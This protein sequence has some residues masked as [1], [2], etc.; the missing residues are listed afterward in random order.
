MMRFIGLQF[1]GI[2]P[3]VREYSID[4]SALSASGMFLIQGET[5]SGKSTILDAIT[6]ALYDS[7]S[8]DTS[9]AGRMRSKFLQM[10]RQET[11]TDLIFEIRNHV[12]RVRREPQYRI[13]KVR[14]EG[15]T[16]HRASATLWQIDDNIRALYDAPDERGS[17]DRFFEYAEQHSTVLG[18]KANDVA[19]ELA[20]IIGLTRKQFTTTV[21]LAQGQ[22]AKLLSMQPEERTQLLADLVDAHI[23]EQ[24]QRELQEERKQAHAQVEQQQNMLLQHIL[25]MRTIAQEYADFAGTHARDIREQLA[26]DDSNWCV[27]EQ[28]TLNVPALSIEDIEHQ[29]Q[30]NTQLMIQDIAAWQEDIAQHIDETQQRW[31]Q[32]R[33]CTEYANTVT[34]LV[35]RLQQYQEEIVKQIEQQAAI[36][37]YQ[38][39]LERAHDAAPIIVTLREFDTQQ[40]ERAAAQQHITQL[41]AQLEQLPQ[42]DALQAQLEQARAAQTAMLDLQHQLEQCRRQ[43]QLWQTYRVAQAEYEQANE[44]LDAQNQ[45]VQAAKQHVVDYGSSKSLQTQIEQLQQQAQSYATAEQER[46]SAQQALTHAKRA[47]QLSIKEEEL[48][49]RLEH[50]EQQLNDANTS[51]QLAQQ[52]ITRDENARLAA[53]LQDG[54]PCPVCGSLEHPDPV[55]RPDHVPDAEFVARLTKQQQ[56][57]QTH[58]EQLN[59]QYAAMHAELGTEEQ[60]A[61]GGVEQCEQALELAQERLAQYEQYAEQITA[62]QTKLEHAQELE[63]HYQSSEHEAERLQALCTTKQALAQQAYKQLDS[64]QREEDIHARIEE[65]N[66]QL[67]QQQAQADQLDALKQQMKLLERIAQDIATQRALL[68]KHTQSI[69]RLNA[70]IEQACKQAN[71]ADSKAVRQAMLSDGERE[72]IETA[73][74]TYEHA[75]AATDEQGKQ[76]IAQLKTM[77][78]TR[79]TQLMDANEA[80]LALPG[81]DIDALYTII[82]EQTS[83]RERMADYNAVFASVEAQ[84]RTLDVT[85]LQSEEAQAMVQRDQARQLATTVEHTHTQIERAIPHLQEALQQWASA[86]RNY[87]PIRAM[88]ALANATPDSPAAEKM[89]LI[90]YSVTERC[91]DM[92]EHANEIL[93]DIQGGIYELRLDHSNVSRNRKLGLPISV[94]DRRSDTVRA[95]ASLSG[96]ETFFVS[97][98]LALALADEMSAGQGGLSLQT[99]FIDEGFGSLSDDYLDDVIEVLHAIARHRAI[100]II[101]HVERLKDQVPAGIHVSR[102][103]ADGESTLQVHA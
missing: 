58:V 57:Y 102:M 23:F 69:E 17:A 59:I 35:E 85:R 86:Y 80:F 68:D 42:Q 28:H 9:D 12:Y 72:E 10:S 4:F 103:R 87:E 24:V 63:Q 52:A 27:T 96:G 40:Q 44:Q 61:Q 22:F 41:I 83:V 74:Q 45:A 32:A 91:K 29:L 70:S 64:S 2:G 21:M 84:V 38:T 56:E 66:A 33:Q 77:N 94:Y 67:E 76:A 97:L 51:L 34:Q 15:F 18:T 30:A 20:S 1:A 100:G 11:Y 89:S 48:T 50:I 55:T 5:G 73:I 14:G 88:A 75:C 54:K 6:M 3:Y 99:M 36:A 39:R 47:Q 82:V 90:T 60:L 46:D 19:Q 79:S 16:E 53:Q 65:L 78:D 43:E 31:Q 81:S 98:S 71:F 95:A 13:P 101:S 37:Q 49:A 62:L 26:L 8:S 92:L 93:R 7:V 25:N